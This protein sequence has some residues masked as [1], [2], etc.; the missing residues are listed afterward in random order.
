MY[1]EFLTNLVQIQ[2]NVWTTYELSLDEYLG[3]CRP[4]AA[5]AKHV[6]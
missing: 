4:L 1:Y 3:K 5:Y 6:N 2:N